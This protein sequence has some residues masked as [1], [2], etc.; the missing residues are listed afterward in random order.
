MCKD[1]SCFDCATAKDSGGECMHCENCIRGEEHISEC[2]EH[3]S[4]E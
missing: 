3:T 2:N 4:I 1:C